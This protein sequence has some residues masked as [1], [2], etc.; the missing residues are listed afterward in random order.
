MGFFQNRTGRHNDVTPGNRS[1]RCLN[2]L[3]I[4]IKTGLDLFCVYTRCLLIGIKGFHGLKGKQHVQCF[5][6]GSALNTTS[7]YPDNR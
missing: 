6:I 1:F 5:K 3:Y 2:N 7:Q 4:D